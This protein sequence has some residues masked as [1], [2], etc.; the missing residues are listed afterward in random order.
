VDHEDNI[1]DI[2]VQR[3]R[4]K[5]AA[6][7]VF[8]KLFKGLTC[9]PR[10]IITDQLKS[11]GA[12]KR[13]MLPSVEHRQYRYLNNRAEPPNRRARGNGGCSDSNPPGHAQRVSAAYGPIS[14]QFRPRRHLRPAS[15]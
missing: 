10:V 12:A 3:R 11:Y 5:H 15:V 6:K 2:L 4:D 9:V 1:L 7:K 14:S 8:R 13:E